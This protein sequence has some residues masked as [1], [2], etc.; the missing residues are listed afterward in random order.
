MVIVLVVVIVFVNSNNYKWKWTKLGI[1]INKFK[2]IHLLEYQNESLDSLL[3]RILGLIKQSTLLFHF[4]ILN[5]F[6]Y[7]EFK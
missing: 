6:S 7:L 2:F 4:Y 5:E 1:C 3:G